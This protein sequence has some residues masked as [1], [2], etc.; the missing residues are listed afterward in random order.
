MLRQRMTEEVHLLGAES[1]LGMSWDP[2]TL[3]KE[4]FPKSHAKKNFWI[5]KIQKEVPEFFAMLE[6]MWG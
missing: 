3:R 4:D 6:N 1:H 2:V 5:P